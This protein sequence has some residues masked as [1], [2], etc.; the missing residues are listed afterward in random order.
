MND[1][2]KNIN[3]WDLTTTNLGRIA[4][5]KYQVAVL[6]VGA[7]EPHNRHLPQGQDVFHTTYIAKKCCEMAWKKSQSVICLPTIPY[8]VDC[9]LMAFPLAIHVSQTTL[10]T[11]VR[12]I[13][14]SLHTHGIRKI[15]IIN[16]HGGNEFK[17]LI[18]QIQCDMDV[19]VFLC[20]WWRVGGDKY[21]EIFTRPDDHA[22]QMETSISMALFPELVEFES[23]SDGG[24]RDYRFGALRRG[25]V[26][27]SRDFARLNDHCA[28]GDPAGSCAERGERYIEVVC[29]RISDFLAE[30][31]ES[32]IDD[33]FPH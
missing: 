33:V 11:I 23:A 29:R 24:V 25:W 17:P 31:A 19:F 16:G 1:K 4:K 5:R 6:P 30:L 15:V 14:V 18:R 28:S 26:E 9:N 21:N 12:E 20:N 27:T 10:D 22:G 7:V 32:E 3:E 8:G 13:I 2:N